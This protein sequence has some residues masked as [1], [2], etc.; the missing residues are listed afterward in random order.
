MQGF[1]IEHRACPRCQIM[2]T[3]SFGR[4]LFCFNCRWSSETAAIAA[5]SSD[6]YS[7]SPEELARLRVYRAALRDGFY[8]DELPA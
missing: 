1:V 4:T 2:R 7:F 8:T 6:S 5:A 3:V